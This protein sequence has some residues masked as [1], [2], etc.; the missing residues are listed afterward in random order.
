MSSAVYRMMLIKRPKKV[1]GEGSK[2][3][4]GKNK[5]A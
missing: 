3:N 1:A 4:S 5:G 2:E